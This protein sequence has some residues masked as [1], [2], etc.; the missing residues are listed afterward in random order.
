MAIKVDDADVIRLMSHLMQR[1]QNPAPILEQ[2]GDIV[3]SGVEENFAREGRY[4]SPGAWLGGGQK[5]RALRPSTLRRRKNKGKDAKILQDTG[6]LAGSIAKTVTENSVIVGTNLPYAAAHQFGARINMPARPR[7]L[8]FRKYKKGQHKG[9]TLFARPEKAQ[10]G[11]K[12]QGKAYMVTIPA[13]P[14]LTIHP[15]DLQEIKDVLTG[16]VTEQE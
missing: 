1:A 9:K 6:T 16:F 10:F 8:H 7:I 12:V 5:W 11:Q 3:I 15:D 13:R 2:I 4:S 14:F